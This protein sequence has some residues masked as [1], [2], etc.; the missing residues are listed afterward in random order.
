MVNI[1]VSREQIT[2]AWLSET[3]NI[4]AGITAKVASVEVEPILAGYYGTS[5]RLTI[6]YEQ[7]DDSLPHS[8]FLKMASEHEAARENAA[9]EGMYRYEVGFYKDLANKVNISTPY[10]YA[11]EISDDNSAFVL[12]LEDAAPFVQFDQLEGLD[13]TQAQLAV[14]ELAGLHATTWQGKGMED[15]HW[16]KVSAEQVEAYAQ[17]MVQLVPVFIERFSDDLSS[18]NVEMIKRLVMQAPAYWRYQLDA[19]NQVATHCDY[20]CDNMLFGQKDGKHA[21][22]AI[23]WVGMFC[24]GGRDL[25]HFLGTSLLPEVRSENEVVLLTHYHNALQAQGINDFTLQ[26]CIDD[27]RINLFYPIFVAV[28]ASASVDVDARGKKLFLSM[29]NRA[30]AA[31]R[32]SNA[33]QLIEAL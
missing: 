17:V 6:K 29:V 10:C 27:Y 22:V 3:L 8:L 4:A 14:Q 11:A 33:M 20:R 5:S 24:C 28:T 18:E 25:G 12:L 19:K 15:C 32:D 13:P 16:A 21:M 9:K 31:M 30:C 7:G 2:S 26:A 1:I 23:D